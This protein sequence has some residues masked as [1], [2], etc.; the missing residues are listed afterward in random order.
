MKPNSIIY[1]ISFYILLI[2][3]ATVSAHG[4]LKTIKMDPSKLPKGMK[5]EGKIKN[6][7][8]WTDSFGD[9]IV[10]TTETG[11][12][13]NKSLSG[14]YNKN[15]A[16]YA[17]HYNIKDSLRLTWKVHDLITDC[18]VDVEA[19][20]V[21][22]TLQVTD[23]NKDGVGEVWL[24][25][26][27]ACRGDVSPADMKIIMYQGQQKFAMRGQNK[28]QVSEK[29]FYGGEYKFD[30]AFIEAPQEFKIFAKKLWDKNILETWEE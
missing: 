17:Y 30:K 28:V 9:N 23:L 27:T 26:K 21:K 1:K 15:A 20:F 25:Y 3:F 16:L 6:A 22:N 14:E 8:R 10:L 13:R 12:T 19:N 18:E 4:Q 7:I 5:Y 24:M 11:E 29:E 2:L